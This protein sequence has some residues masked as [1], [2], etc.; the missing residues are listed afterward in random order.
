LW[1]PV[2]LSRAVA[3]NAASA[4]ASNEIVVG[5]GIGV[6][7]GT[8]GTCI[9]IVGMMSVWPSPCHVWNQPLSLTATARGS[10]ATVRVRVKSLPLANFTTSRRASSERGDVEGSI[11][12]RSAV[13]GVQQER[14]ECGGMWRFASAGNR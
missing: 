1:R 4:I 3:P 13:G 10:V 5:S 8:H 12:I 2:T 14:V 6:R 7:P 11:D 9:P